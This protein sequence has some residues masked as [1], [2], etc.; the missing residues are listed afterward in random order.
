MAD[1]WQ[2]LLA[3]AAREDEKV[4]KKYLVVCGEWRRAFFQYTAHPIPGEP[5]RGKKTLLDRFIADSDSSL[6]AFPYPS[7]PQQPT[8]LP[9]GNTRNK[10]NISASTGPSFLTRN[11]AAYAANGGSSLLLSS[12]AEGASNNHT[13]K[14]HTPG[15]STRRRDPKGKEAEHAE[16]N[17]NASPSGHPLRLDVLDDKRLKSTEGMLVGYEWIDISQQGEAGPSMPFASK[18][19]VC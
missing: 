19:F 18:S 9:R 4:P 10:A 7:T 1:I 5:R 15:N 11:H 8:T 13:S 17:A 14:T 6:A 3:G 2:Q 12:I 16:E